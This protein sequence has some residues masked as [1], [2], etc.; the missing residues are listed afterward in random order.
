[1]APENKYNSDNQLI[2]DTFPDS[3]KLFINLFAENL[4]EDIRK[5]EICIY[6]PDTSKMILKT[7]KKLKNHSGI[8]MPQE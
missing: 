7:S 6:L 1:M 2:Q 8:I 4:Y 5:S 3:E